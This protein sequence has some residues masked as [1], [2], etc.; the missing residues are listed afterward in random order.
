MA[1]EEVR[2]LSAFSRLSSAVRIAQRT[3]SIT[4]QSTWG[5]GLTAGAG[6]SAGE[7]WFLQVVY[8]DPLAGLCGVGFNATQGVQITFTP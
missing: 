8:R 3:G 6:W 5:T 7:T 1:L 2:T 4:G